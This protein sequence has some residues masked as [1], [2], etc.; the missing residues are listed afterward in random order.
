MFGSALL[1]YLNRA[2]FGGCVVC[3]YVCVTFE[4]KLV[5]D[6]NNVV[7]NIVDVCLDNMAAFIIFLTYNDL[8]SSQT[9]ID[10]VSILP[11]A[12]PLSPRSQCETRT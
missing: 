9:I 7:D 3:L 6:G 11:G 4:G 12:F 1:F 2:G 8:F 10:N 5:H